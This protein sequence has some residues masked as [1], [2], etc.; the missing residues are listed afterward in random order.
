MNN[1]D[2]QFTFDSDPF[3]VTVD[4]KKSNGTEIKLGALVEVRIW[5]ANYE[6]K[7][8]LV[9]SINSKL[10][11][12]SNNDQFC[13][14][15][16]FLE[17]CTATENSDGSGKNLTLLEGGK[18]G[19][20]SVSRTVKMTLTLIYLVHRNCLIAGSK[21]QFSSHK[22]SQQYTTATIWWW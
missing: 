5:I 6:N 15:I 20:L 9:R 17:S 11:A 18:V 22:S 16:K 13:H 4:G 10:V 19:D 21:L 7:I 8:S 14:Q 12:L 2:K 1:A 3:T